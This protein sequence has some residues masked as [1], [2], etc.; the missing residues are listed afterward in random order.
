MTAPWTRRPVLITGG[1]GFVGSNLAHALL[2]DGVRVRVLDDLSRAGVEA[3]L[4]WLRDEH[5][6]EAL[7]TIV[8]DVADPATVGAAVD[9]VDAVFHLAAQVAVTASIDDPRRDFATNVLGT[10][11]ILEA[12][13]A[14]PSPVP[15]VFTSTNKVYGELEAVR[16]VAGPTRYEPAGN[17]APF[18]GVDEST[19]L[20]F[21]SPYGCSK[22][23]ADQYVLDYA[24]TY[25]VPAVVFRMSCIYGPHQFGTED[26]GWVAHFVIRALED[27]PITIFG[28][29]K[30]VRDVLF[31]DDLVAAFRLAV[32]HADRIAGQAFNIGGGPQRTTSLLELTGLIAELEGRPPRVDFA[33]WR[34]GDQR[35]YVSDPRRFMRAVGW[36]PTVGVTEGVRR[37]H[38]WLRSERGRPAATERVVAQGG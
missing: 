15:I 31:I 4:A 5:G 13:R 27:R 8:G 38:A 22:G 19:P 24:R 11:R 33:P 16:V 21:R 34:L 18:H 14:L 28:D 17:G 20:D 37:L 2:G 9:G 30:Q 6:E 10:L 29:G 12:I 1:A 35:H 25:G 32:D 23:A 7:E 3:N 26:Q 36:A